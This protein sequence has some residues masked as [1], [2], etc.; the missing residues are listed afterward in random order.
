VSEQAAHAPPA[1]FLAHTGALLTPLF[2]HA[3]PEPGCGGAGDGR[4]EGSKLDDE[5]LRREQCTEGKNHIPRQSHPLP[6]QG[7]VIEGNAARVGEAVFLNSNELRPSDREEVEHN[8]ERQPR[9]VEP[10]GRHPELL[11][12][13]PARPRGPTKFQNAAPMM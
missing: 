6:D 5:I 12:E 10:E 3:V 1:F 11:V 9:I 13:R 8:P 4:I 7:L 2:A